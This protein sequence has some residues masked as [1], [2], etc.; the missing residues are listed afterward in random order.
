M[1]AVILVEA[2]IHGLELIS[3]NHGWQSSD[4]MK[5]APYSS[6]VLC[7]IQTA[8]TSVQQLAMDKLSSYPGAPKPGDS[9]YCMKKLQEKAVFCFK[10]VCNQQK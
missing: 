7:I 9:T 8:M 6:N 4:S 10:H 1:T 5:S 2:A 3:I